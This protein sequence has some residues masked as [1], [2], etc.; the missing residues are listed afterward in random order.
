MPSLI[1]PLWHFHKTRTTVPKIYLEPFLTQNC[2]SIPEDQ[3]QSRRQNPP[4]LRRALQ[5]YSTQNKEVLA[6]RQAC[7]AMAQNTDSRRKPT[8][9]RSADL[10]WR[11]KNT[12]WG[13]VSTTTSDE[14]V[15]QAQTSH[16]SESTH[17]PT[18]KRNWGW[19]ADL[20]RRHHAPNS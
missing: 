15:G 7:G 18:K 9:P 6:Q 3:E 8:H 13:K 10:W 11:N 17:T 14:E 5:S 16:K 2:Q 20:N 12:Q 19:L 4:R 1:N